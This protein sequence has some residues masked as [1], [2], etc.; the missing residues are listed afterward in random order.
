MYYFWAYGITF[1]K[2]YLIGN[3]VGYYEMEIGLNPTFTMSSFIKVGIS[4]LKKFQ[5]QFFKNERH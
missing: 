4:K 5:I 3:K 2:N 1:L